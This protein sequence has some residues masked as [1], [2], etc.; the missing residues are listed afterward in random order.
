MA[1]D[2]LTGFFNAR[3]FNLRLTTQ[4]NKV[5]GSQQDIALALI[6]V[7]HHSEKNDPESALRL[8]R[9]LLRSVRL[10]HTITRDVD[11]IGR[12]GG[13]VLALAMPGIPMGEDLNNRLA[14]LV[15]LGLMSDS[16]DTQP[17]ELRF[18]IAV[19][20]RGTWGNDLK[21]LDN[22]LRGAIMQSTGWSRRPIHYITS[23]IAVAPLQAGIREDMSPVGAMVETSNSDSQGDPP[24]LNAS[25][26]SSGNHNGAS[27]SAPQSQ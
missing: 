25:L 12:V 16:Y 4:W 3:A 15:A 10:L 11:L 13:N 9:K 23:G 2:P 6:H 26:R 19:G 18:R 8:E 21:S 27:S 7:H 5:I 24:A 14:R 20:T 22:H 1:V 17:T